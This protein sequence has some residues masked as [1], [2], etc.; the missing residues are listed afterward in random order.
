M[1][2]HGTWDNDLS[3]QVKSDFHKCCSPDMSSTISLGDDQLLDISAEI[4]TLRCKFV[5]Q[6]MASS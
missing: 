3:H 4:F 5:G 2:S 1:N 6:E